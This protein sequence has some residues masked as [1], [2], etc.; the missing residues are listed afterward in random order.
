MAGSETVYGGVEGPDAMYVKLISSDG[1]E[2][3]IKKDLALTSGTIK[4]MLSG[5]GSYS[6]NETNEV[7]FR[8]IPSHVLQKVCQ[9]FAYKVR[10]TN[11]ATEIPE[12]SI[13]PEVALELLMAANFLD[14]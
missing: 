5:P 3:I 1:H 6:E 9:Y 2:F 7:N 8:E 10:Y 14:C 13:A 11:S 12:F 4:A